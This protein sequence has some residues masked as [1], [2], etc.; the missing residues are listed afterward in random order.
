MEADFT[1]I[2]DDAAARRIE[3]QGN[4]REGSKRNVERGGEYVG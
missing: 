2:F 1:L 3:K 4:K